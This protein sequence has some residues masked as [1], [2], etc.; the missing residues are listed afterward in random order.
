MCLTVAPN[1]QD[2]PSV[3][4]NISEPATAF[5]ETT[6]LRLVRARK[7]APVLLGGRR[8]PVAPIKNPLYGISYHRIRLHNPANM[9]R[10]VEFFVRDTDLYLAGFWRGVVPIPADGAAQNEP[11]WGTLF[12]FDDL[13]EEVPPFFHAV[14]MGINSNHTDKG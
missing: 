11:N 14:K 9:S 6:R 2:V 7:I 1:L 8:I 4:F 13:Y 10:V 3:D 5:T 12:I